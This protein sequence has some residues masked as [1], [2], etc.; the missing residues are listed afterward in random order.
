MESHLSAVGWL[1]PTSRASDASTILFPF[2]KKRFCGKK[3]FVES[4]SIFFAQR[5]SEQCDQPQ[6]AGQGLADV[7]HHSELLGAAQKELSLFMISV[8]HH[9]YLRE[10][11]GGFLNFVDKNWRRI[12]LKKTAALFC[13]P[14]PDKR[15]VESHVARLRCEF[16]QHSGLPHLSGACDEHGS[17]HGGQLFD[18]LFSMSFYVQISSL[19]SANLIFSIRIAE[20]TR[21]N[22][23]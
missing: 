13:C 19:P 1:I 4:H 2:G 6:S 17:K 21:K 14:C 9:F 8:D 12:V 16:P 11:F 23:C 7:F 22:K 18:S 3:R 15:I 10:Q 20:K 5:K